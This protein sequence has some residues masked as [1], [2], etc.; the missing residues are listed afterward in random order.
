MG[1]SSSQQRY[2]SETGDFSVILV[3]ESGGKYLSFPL[4]SFFLVKADAW[5]FG[6]HLELMRFVEQIFG[7]RRRHPCLPSG[8]REL[9]LVSYKQITISLRTK[10]SA[11]CY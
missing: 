8:S 9:A 5:S 4:A 1:H 7:H 6:S 2:K 11:P 3:P 10:S